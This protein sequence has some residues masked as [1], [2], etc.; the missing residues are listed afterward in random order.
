MP[1]TVS[2]YAIGVWLAVGLFTG[3]GW[4]IAGLLISRLF[5]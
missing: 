1:S 4:A 3:L 2:L 5:R